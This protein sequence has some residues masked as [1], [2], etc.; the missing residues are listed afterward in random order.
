MPMPIISVF[1]S[2]LLN[3]IPDQK[4]GLWV[5]SL[6]FIVASFLINVYLIKKNNTLRWELYYLEKE[7]LERKKRVAKIRGETLSD[8]VLD[9]EVKEPIDNA[10]LPIPY[11]GILLIIDIV[12][13]FMILDAI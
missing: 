4:N 12:I 5:M 2:R 11:Y 7:S 13:K 8:Y 10:T 3:T 9:K 1:V 6:L